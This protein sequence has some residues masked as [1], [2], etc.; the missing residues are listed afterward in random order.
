[1]LLCSDGLYKGLCESD[2]LQILQ[3]GKNLSLVKLCKQLVRVSNDKDGQDNIS[4]VLIKILPPKPL[5]FK[6]KIKRFFV[7]SRNA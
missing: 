4:A 7:F 2:M 3:E 6:Q 1:M 5:S